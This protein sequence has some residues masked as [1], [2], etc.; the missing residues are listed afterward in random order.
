MVKIMQVG[1]GY[2]GDNVAKKLWA[3]DCFELVCLADADSKKCK[4]A[5]RDYP[6]IVV[7]DNYKECLNNVDAVAI[8]TQTQYSYDIAMEA[9]KVGKHI[10]I[11]KPLA[12]T[13]KEAEE[14]CE[15][16]TKQNIILHCDHL[17]VYN[18]VIRYIKDMIDKDEL[19]EIMYID[20]SRVNLGPIRRDINAMLDLAVHDIAV[21]DYILGGLEPDRINAYG[22]KFFGDQETITYLNMKMGETLININSSW[23]SP[24]KIRRSIIAG[25][26]KMVIFDDVASDKLTIYDSGIDVMR[27]K[28]YG[29]YEFKTRIGDIYIPRL[30][31]EDALKNSLEAFADSVVTG[32]QSLS[33]PEPSL[34]V[35]K[36]LEKAQKLLK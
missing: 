30:E 14:L 20:I 25:T 29:E 31:F 34:R 28:V 11:E 35:M 36:I 1:Y 6:S 8:C 9:M 33:G 7:T 10:F 19:G 27:G 15:E 3:S 2:W 5:E 18:H 24:V 23:I 21:A 13:V 17:M 4:Y 32:K 22:T 16:A 26:K 12:R